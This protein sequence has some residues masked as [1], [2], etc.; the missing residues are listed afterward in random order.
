MRRYDAGFTLLEILV[1]LVVVAVAMGGAS[2]AIDS[3]G[4][5]KELGDMVE[6]FTAYAEHASEMAVLSGEPMGL[7]LEPPSWQSENLDAGWRFRWQKLTYEGWV[8]YEYL[9]PV[10][11]PNTINLFVTIEGELWEWED[12]PKVKLPAIAFYPG[13]DLTY[14]EIEFLLDDFSET[15]EHV[16][17]DEWGR[18]VWVEK[19]EMMQQ[20][21]EELND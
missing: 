12:A 11:I 4:P 16:K 15:S 10:N 21:E 2:L 1:V 13:G 18:I 5:E 6:K 19:E 9:P 17:V 3:G 8:D 20:L 14:F 7:L